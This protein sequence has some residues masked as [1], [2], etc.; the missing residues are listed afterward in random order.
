MCLEDDLTCSPSDPYR[1]IEIHIAG[2]PR[3]SALQAHICD[4]QMAADIPNDVVRSGEGLPKV[5]PPCPIDEEH[6]SDIPC[7]C[8]GFL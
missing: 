5:A 4:L 8:I 7:Y 3:D 1:L 2:I 6:I